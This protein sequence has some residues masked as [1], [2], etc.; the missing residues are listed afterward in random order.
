MPKRK[1][2]KEGMGSPGDMR[3]R[4]RDAYKPGKHKAPA[5]PLDSLII[6]GERMV[7]KVAKRIKGK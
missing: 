7:K 3:D 4:F 6:K 1:M 2:G 5:Q